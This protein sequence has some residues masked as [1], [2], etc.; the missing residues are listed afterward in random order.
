MPAQRLNLLDTPRART[1]V[2]TL[3]YASEGAPIGFIWWAMPALLRAAE[4]PIERIT[5]LTA[6][7][8]LPWV[9]KF[10]WAPLVDT[11][12]SRYWG[13]RAWIVTAQLMM[14]LMLLPLIWLDPVEHFDTWR[15]LLLAHAF[16]AATQDVAIDALAI[17]SVP[18]R[19]RGLL[20]GCMQAGMLVG[21]SLFGGGALLVAATLGR[22]WM[23]SAL[24]AWIWLAM[25]VLMF[26]REPDALAP[27]HERLA[28]FRRNLRRALRRRVVWIGIAVALI[29]GAGFEATGQLAGPFLIDR[30]VPPATIGLFFGV[31]AVSATLIGGLLGGRLSDRWGRIR[32][33]GVFLTGL[34]ASI[35]ALALADLWGSREPSTLIGLLVVMYFFIGLFTASSYALFMD[36]TDPALGGTQ[37]S[38]Y[39]AATNGCESWSAWAGGQVAG[40]AGYAP[41]FLT[42][43][44]VSLGGL[45][46]LWLLSRDEAAE[47][48]A[49]R[50][51]PVPLA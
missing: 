51:P 1:A 28:E 25:L 14:G 24:V 19:D 18:P 50:R 44:T 5:G 11:L 27:S 31:F 7:V 47:G 17:N 26:V 43:T 30:E 42:M 35:I 23:I 20:N 21:R 34:S 46:L 37:F 8:V 33:V 48:P 15:L 12:R 10:A 6:L 13:F 49:P 4:L 32:S 22:G 9:F 39:M 36:L 38:T 29:S 16:A 41:A 3:L 2:F 45:A 40:R